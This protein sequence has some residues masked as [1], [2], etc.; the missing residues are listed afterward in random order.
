MRAVLLDPTLLATES[1]I[2]LAVRL[3]PDEP[4]GPGSDWS[5]SKV[6]IISLTLGAVLVIPLLICLGHRCYLTSKRKK[7][8]KNVLAA[9]T[10]AVLEARMAA[11]A[12]AR[13][14]GNH[15]RADVIQAI[16]DRDAAEQATG[17]EQMV[18][19]TGNLM[20][21]YADQERPAVGDEE[22]PAGGFGFESRADGAGIV[23]ASL[24]QREAG[25]PGVGLGTRPI[26]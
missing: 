4:G 6:L 3:T 18:H 17:K 8:A 23:G 7:M 2:Q 14:E 20:D 21:R 10:A 5:A 24:D 13:A 25:G 12:E 9:R 1:A 15:A 11:V 22:A 19:R 16:I 26:P